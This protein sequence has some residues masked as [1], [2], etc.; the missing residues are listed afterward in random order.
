MG[1]RH[2]IYIVAK[3]KTGY[4]ALSAYHHQWCYGMRAASN[5]YR[6]VN[7][8]NK[9]IR[10]NW[11]DNKLCTLKTDTRYMD[12]AIKSV[13]GIDLNGELSMV[14]DCNDYLIDNRRIL[15]HRGDNNDGCTLIVVDFVKDEIRACLFAIHGVE[16]QHW[17]GDNYKAYTPEQYLKFY[18]TDKE[19]DDK[20]FKKSFKQHLFI[21]NNMEIKPVR[22]QELRKIVNYKKLKGVA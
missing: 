8:L 12:S 1:Q 17:N 18:Y 20:E 9:G 3:D 19:Q 7:T 16:G 6:L 15:P 5:A 2:Q 10:S 14:H 13:Y 21:M 22:T 11:D 4:K